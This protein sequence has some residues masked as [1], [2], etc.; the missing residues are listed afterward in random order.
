MHNF[1]VIFMTEE[2]YVLNIFVRTND[3]IITRIQHVKKLI[4]VYKRKKLRHVGFLSLF[5]I[6]HPIF[7]HLG[8]DYRD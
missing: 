7:Y 1:T 4:K 5:T 8:Y 2:T 3:R 6:L